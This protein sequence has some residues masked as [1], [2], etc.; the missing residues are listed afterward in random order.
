VFTRR[1]RG[2]EEEGEEEREAPSL[3][4]PDHLWEKS[5]TYGFGKTNFKKGMTMVE[6]IT[7][8]VEMRDVQPFCEF[9]HCNNDGA[10]K[11]LGKW[12]CFDHIVPTPKSVD[13]FDEFIA[14]ARELVEGRAKEKGYNE[15]GSGR[16]DL[17]EFTNKFFPGHAG[18]EI[19]YKAIRYGRKHD[20]TDLLKIAAWAYLLWRYDS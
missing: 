19:V 9:P 3:R 7:P 6:K 15:S 20:K 13:S 1:G 11:I 10:H 5:T 4:W 12:Y 17:M 8:K 16:N 14:G 2:C 18:G